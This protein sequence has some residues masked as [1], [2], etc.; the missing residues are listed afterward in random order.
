MAEKLIDNVEQI[1]VPDS[2]PTSTETK[3]TEISLQR[4][5]GQNLQQYGI[6]GALVIIVVFFQIVTGGLLLMPNSFVNLIQQNAYVL[7]LAMG[8]VM[9]IV[10]TH[11]DLSVGSQVALIGAIAAV[12]M[13]EMRL[14]WYVA[15]L[16]CIGVGLLIGAWHGFWV[17]YVGIPGFIVTLSGMLLFRGFATVLAGESIPIKSEFY[18][19]IA[20]N[21]VP[22]I[23]GFIPNPFNPKGVFDVFT[24]VLGLFAIAAV[25]YL[26]FKKIRNA[27]QSGTPMPGSAQAWSLITAAVACALILFATYLLA[28][29]G[30]VS[31][32]GVRQGGIPVTLVIVA[33]PFAFYTFLTTK[34]V[35]GRHIYATGGNRKA[36]IL[37]GINTKMV[38]FRIY[39]HMGFLVAIA[40]LYMLSR[41][42]SATAVAGQ[43][44]EL[45][46]IASCFIGGTAVTGGI[47]TV[48]GAM[49]GAFVM[50]VLNQGLSLMGVSSAWVKAIKGLVLLAAVALD[51]L[52]KRRSK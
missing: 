48:P 32:D 51:I 27:K 23:L 29:S 30:N 18:R 46:A 12:L 40:S 26:R 20:K 43:E 14:P 5:I 41:S 34:T 11:I 35:F 15:V 21:Y 16:V 7:L 8:M 45:D 52:S 38:D 1:E 50:G 19:D 22:N 2:G 42:A 10:D 3:T 37:S 17:A 31:A 33:V 44:F 24:V 9:I 39:V 25:L 4:L 13:E 47:G 6:I 36:A 28:S 49:I